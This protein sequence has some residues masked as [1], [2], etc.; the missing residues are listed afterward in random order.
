MGHQRRVSVVPLLP[1]KLSLTRVSLYHDSIV[2]TRLHSA[3]GDRLADADPACEV[4]D[5]WEWLSESGGDIPVVVPGCGQSLN[6]QLGTDEASARR[7][8]GNPGQAVD[9]TA[10][11]ASLVLEQ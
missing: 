8:A 4:V 7:N 2:Y 3:P 11:W 9:L 5:R 6:V 10:H 1:K